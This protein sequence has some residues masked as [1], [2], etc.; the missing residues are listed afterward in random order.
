MNCFV[1]INLDSPEKERS[2]SPLHSSK[3]QNQS[4]SKKPH[5]IEKKDKRHQSGFKDSDLPKHGQIVIEMPKHGKNDIEM[6]KTRQSDLEMPKSRQTDMSKHRQNDMPKNRQNDTP[7]HGQS[8]KKDLPS[9]MKEGSQKTRKESRSQHFKEPSP[10]LSN[11]EIW[12]IPVVKKVKKDTKK[13]KSIEMIQEKTPEKTPEVANRRSKRTVEKVE[14]GRDHH[15]GKQLSFSAE[16][17][18]L[19]DYLK[20]IEKDL[21]LTDFQNKTETYQKDLNLLEENIHENKIL[22]E[23]KDEPQKPEPKPI[24][25]QKEPK[26]DEPKKLETKPIEEQ[27]VNNPSDEPKIILDVL[28]L[29]NNPNPIKK[30]EI[31]K[32][33]EEPQPRQQLVTKTAACS[34]KKS[35]L[36]KEL[37][38]KVDASQESSSDLLKEIIQETKKVKQQQMKTMATIL[39]SKPAFHDLKKFLHSAHHHP[40][41]PHNKLSTFPKNHATMKPK[42]LFTILREIYE[43]F[44]KHILKDQEYACDVC[45]GK[46]SDNNNLILICDLCD[47]AVHQNCYG[48]ELIKFIPEGNWYCCRCRYLIDNQLDIKAVKCVFCPELKGIIKM[49][50]GSEQLWG[51]VSCV[52]NTP[53]VSYLDGK[54]RETVSL[55]EFYKNQLPNECCLCEVEYGACVSCEN[56][57]CDRSFHVTCGCRQGFIYH[58]GSKY[59]YLCKEHQGNLD[60]RIKNRMHRKYS[61]FAKFPEKFSL[62]LDKDDYP[63]VSKPERAPSKEKVAKKVENREKPMKELTSKESDLFETDNFFIN[64]NDDDNVN[65]KPKDLPTSSDAFFIEIGKGN[66]RK[67]QPKASA[68]EIEEEPAKKPAIVHSEL[69]RK[70]ARNK[71]SYIPE[72]SEEDLEKNK[73]KEAPKNN[74]DEEVINQELSINFSLEFDKPQEV[75]E[76]SSEGE[77]KKSEGQGQEIQIQLNAVEEAKEDK[78]RIQLSPQEPEGEKLV[79]DQKIGDSSIEINKVSPRKVLV[80]SPNK[81]VPL[82]LPQET[83]KVLEV[84]AEKE[85]KPQNIAVEGAGILEK[86]IEEALPVEKKNEK[87]GSSFEIMERP[88]ESILEQNKEDEEKKKDEI[89]EKTKQII[90]LSLEIIERPADSI[91]QSNIFQEPKEQF[92]NINIEKNKENTNVIPV[93]IIEIANEQELPKTIN[94]QQLTVINEPIG[95]NMEKQKEIVIEEQPKQVQ[96]TPGKHEIKLTDLF[97]T[98]VNTDPQNQIF[99]ERE[100]KNEDSK[101]KEEIQKKQVVLVER[102]EIEEEGNRV[103][104][105]ETKSSFLANPDR[106]KLYRDVMAIFSQHSMDY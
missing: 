41:Q 42:L 26:I 102:M 35:S 37:N 45:L 6:P 39:P 73:E 90:D 31:E 9:D 78:I 19:D 5:Q 81:E 27:I 101:D 82:V 23:M 95:E 22:E 8:D 32:P 44:R 21:N 80:K 106:N 46:E 64:L 60:R 17:L 83:G 47:G 58:E 10:S 93:E 34:S 15:K 72:S 74:R 79:V 59:H 1:Y 103:E 24:E 69:A 11:K 87:E 85:A 28:S 99:I 57:N 16:K 29:D 55:E 3:D 70:S 12:E 54:D 30:N 76:H 96:K 65:I 48:S 13:D 97:A 4:T 36:Q 98:M 91:N 66:E 105:G 104:N 40:N 33:L 88:M 7:K 94:G 51:H 25:Q 75:K 63:W 18:S 68:M 71:L 56:K 53:K 89:E 14:K 84:V 20:Q 52:L 49:I 67:H 38:Q 100:S 2:P 77:K 61:E 86:E 92:S 50:N 43:N 62:M